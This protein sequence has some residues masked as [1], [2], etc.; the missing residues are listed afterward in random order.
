MTGTQDPGR[1]R[2]G[3]SGWQYQSWRGDFYPQDLPARR[4]LSYVAD[5]LATVELN[6]PFY[7]L[8]RPSS[9]RRWYDETPDE[10]VFAVK[11]GRYVTHLKRLRDVQTALANFFASG[12]LL[13][14]EKLG[15][16]LWQLPERV[17]FDRDVVA[18]FLAQLPRTGTEVAAVAAGHDDKVPSTAYDD[19]G[20]DKPV[21]HALEVRSA[22]FRDDDFFALLRDHDVACVLADSAGRWPELDE[23][24]ASFDYLR[25]HGHSELY[26]SRYATATLEGWA[27]RCSAAAEAGRDV[28]VYFDN[29]AHGHAPHDAI[30]LADRLGLREIRLSPR[31]RT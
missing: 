25:L 3:I 27:E 11:G 15:P 10:F 23:T 14:G 4:Q 19:P 21:R 28:Y 18:E 13:L 30:R 2:V 17:E 29:D 26:T 7:S 5:H 12:V 8:Q 16:F 6:G 1:I 22:T 20:L 31:Q 24:T 9:Y